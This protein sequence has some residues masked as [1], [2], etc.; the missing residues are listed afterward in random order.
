MIADPAARSEIGDATVARLSHYLRALNDLA[1]RGVAS[2]SF[3]KL[4]TAAQQRMPLLEVT[5]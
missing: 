3:E 5:T 2:V 4:A 1:W